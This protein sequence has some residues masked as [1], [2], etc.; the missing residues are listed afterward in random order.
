[1]APMPYLCQLQLMSYTSPHLLRNVWHRLYPLGDDPDYRVYQE[2]LADTVYEYH[3]V[4]TLRTSSDSGSYTR[5][6]WS[7]YTSIAS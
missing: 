4:V 2:R 7:G 5:T 3:V 1:M 6:S